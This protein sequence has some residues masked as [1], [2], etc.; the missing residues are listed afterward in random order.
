MKYLKLA[1]MY[2]FIS[3]INALGRQFYDG[4]G[5]TQSDN[6]FSFNLDGLYIMARVTF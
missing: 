5:G 4:C 2:E 1:L 6:C 3:Y